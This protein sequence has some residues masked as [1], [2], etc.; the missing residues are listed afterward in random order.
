MADTKP[1][2]LSVGDEFDLAGDHYRISE[3]CEEP[4][5]GLVVVEDTGRHWGFRVPI[6]WL[7]HMT[8]AKLEAAQ[9]ETAR[10]RNAGPPGRWSC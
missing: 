10:V 9:A 6:T 7:P 8:A 2:A 4:D 1:K 5:M 3:F